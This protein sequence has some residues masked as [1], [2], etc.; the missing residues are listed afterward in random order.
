VV[1][2]GLRQHPRD[3][4]AVRNRLRVLVVPEDADPV[5]PHPEILELREEGGSAVRV[6]K[7]MIVGDPEERPGGCL[8]R[9][10][11]RRGKRGHSDN[12]SHP[13]WHQ[14]LLRVCPP[15]ELLTDN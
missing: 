7:R 2:S 1:C 14:P 3:I 6:V 10:E 12:R 11:Q 4:R 15:L 13:V 5:L 8:A 9:D